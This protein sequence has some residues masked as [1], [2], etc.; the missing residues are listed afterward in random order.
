M[1]Q[2]DIESYKFQ[3]KDFEARAKEKADL[4][5]EFIDNYR[6][7]IMFEIYKNDPKEAPQGKEGIRITIDN[8]MR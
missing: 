3:A 8:S 2:K 6:Q 5:T 7:K 4:Q 1:I